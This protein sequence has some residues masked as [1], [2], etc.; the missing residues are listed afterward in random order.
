MKWTKILNISPVSANISF[1][2]SF[3][4]ANKTSH[5]KQQLLDGQMM[6][7]LEG[8]D[9]NTHTHTQAQTTE[10]LR[11]TYLEMMMMMMTT[12]YVLNKC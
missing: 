1:M 2:P 6:G 7:P 5:N 12:S 9:T 8:D 10:E 11:K 4:K 3:R